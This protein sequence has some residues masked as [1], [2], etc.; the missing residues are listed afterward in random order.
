[1]HL[2]IGWIITTV[3]NGVVPRVG[4]YPSSD[5]G[6]GCRAT[7]GRDNH[8][9]RQGSGGRFSHDSN[10]EIITHSRIR[11]QIGDPEG[12]LRAFCQCVS[13]GIKDVGFRAL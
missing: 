4:A 6:R 12:G 9:R 7:A 5:P 8:Q 10:P 3:V 1:M 11:A 2:G 13:S